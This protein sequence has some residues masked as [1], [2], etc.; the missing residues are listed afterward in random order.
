MRLSREGLKPSVLEDGIPLAPDPH[1]S[2]VRGES[3]FEVVDLLLR[4]ERERGPLRETVLFLESVVVTLHLPVLD[5]LPDPRLVWHVRDWRERHP[6]RPVVPEESGVEFPHDVR[7]RGLVREKVVERHRG[8]PGHVLTVGPE[9][10]DAALAGP[11]YE[12]YSRR[13]PRYPKPSPIGV[14][15][16]DLVLR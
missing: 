14:V 7:R 1:P 16:V 11:I 4:H 8:E 15:E 5:E 13:F 9:R 6:E 10:D 3:R 12:L 2:H